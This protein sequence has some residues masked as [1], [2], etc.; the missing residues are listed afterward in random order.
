[1]QKHLLWRVTGPNT[2]VY[3]LGSVHMLS[4]DVYPLAAPI[5]DAFA[6]AK[7]VV[8]EASLDSLQAHAFDLLMHGQL[9]PGRAL[10]DVIDAATYAGVDSI[11]K[12]YGH[13]VKEVERF[14]PWFV[15]MMI[16]Q[17]ASANAGFSPEYG[18]DNRLD[19]RAKAAGK[20]RLGLE[21]AQ[22]QISIFEQ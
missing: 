5:E 17:L 22:A 7:T 21:S 13:S 8:F 10:H 12:C 3:L 4:P 20:T 18:L 9:P 19:A 16:A 2:T 14:K 15:S 6:H 1:D 11:L